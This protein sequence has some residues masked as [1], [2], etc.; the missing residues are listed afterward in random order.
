L[1]RDALVPAARARDH[2]GARH[3]REHRPQ[4][5]RVGWRRAEA[6]G[7]ADHAHRANHLGRRPELG[8]PRSGEAPC[9]AQQGNNPVADN[10][11]SNCLTANFQTLK[12][13]CPATA[14]ALEAFVDK[15][16]CW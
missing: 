12:G 2:G 3:L 14:T 9:G 1:D 7:Q 6:G 8:A 11:C 10:A 4:R 15:A 5:G 16:Y 13:A